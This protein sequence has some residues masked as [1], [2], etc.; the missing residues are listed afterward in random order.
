MDGFDR[1]PH[2]EPFGELVATATSLQANLSRLEFAVHLRDM[3]EK[4]KLTK[5]TLDETVTGLTKVCED[6]RAEL[7]KQFKPVT[8]MRHSTDTLQ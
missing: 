4:G 3:L 8:E 5:E 6:R 1:R 2:R 7:V